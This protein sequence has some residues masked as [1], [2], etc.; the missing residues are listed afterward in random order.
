MRS[1][2]N[3]GRDGIYLSIDDDRGLTDGDLKEV[4]SRR[5]NFQSIGHSYRITELEAA[6]AVAQLD[7]IF[8]EL[9]KHGLKVKQLIINNVVNVLLMLRLYSG[10]LSP[11]FFA[12]QASSIVAL[13]A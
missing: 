5:F 4:V 1:L 13:T 3:H 9:N 8:G 6:L 7:Y 12:L 11:F 10:F 2:V